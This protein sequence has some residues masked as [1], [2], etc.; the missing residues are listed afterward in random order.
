MFELLADLFLNNWNEVPAAETWSGYD[1]TVTWANAENLGLGEIDRPGVYEISNRGANP[2]TVYNI[3]SL[4][5][6]SA[7]GVL[8]EDNEG[9]IGYAD[10]V[11]NLFPSSQLNLFGSCISFC[12]T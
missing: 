8:Y 1:P 12:L 6:D 10:A 3:A 5:A 11:H 4:I 2:D 7:F 9:R